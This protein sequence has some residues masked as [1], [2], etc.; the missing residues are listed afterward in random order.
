MHVFGIL[1][2]FSGL[3]GLWGA[4]LNGTVPRGR[5]AVLSAIH[6][7]GMLIV[8]VAGFAMAGK[9]GYMGAMP[10]WLY[11]KM[12]I[13]LLLGGSIVLAKRKATIGPLL[14]AVWIALGTLAA[15]L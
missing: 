14:L 8:L 15:Y 4:S 1:M 9:L 2:L 5:R 6:G 10:G 7:F 3:V 11:G 12:L 13:W